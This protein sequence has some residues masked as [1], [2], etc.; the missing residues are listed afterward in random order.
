MHIAGTPDGMSD[1]RDL[2]EKLQ[3]YVGELIKARDEAKERVEKL[4]GELEDATGKLEEAELE[5]TQLKTR[6]RDLEEA[7]ES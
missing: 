3:D 2:Q 5:L 4:E 1:V 6:V 7:G